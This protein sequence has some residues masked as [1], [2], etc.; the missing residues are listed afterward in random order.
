MLEKPDLADDTLV[1]RLREEYDLPISTVGF[2]P[3]GADS[4][5]AVYRAGADGGSVY[6]VKLRS[7]NWLEASVLVPTLLRDR[8]VDAVI[9]PISTAK[10]ELWTSLDAFAVILSPFV[11]GEDGFT[12][13]L[14]ESNWVALGTTLRLLHTTILPPMLH[15]QLP[16]ETY[17][18]EWRIAVKVFQA[19]VEGA[20]FGDPSATEL[21]RMMREQRE[22][23]TT[24]VERA[25]Q[26]ADVLRDRNPDLVLCHA[27]IHSGNV[28]IDAS[29]TLYVVDWDTL[30]IAPKERDLMFIGG[31]IGRGWN[32]PAEDALFYQGYGET[33]IDLAALT[34]YRYERIVQDI[35]AF[36]EQLLDSDE[37]GD[38]RSQALRFFGSQFQPGSVVE[39]AIATD[40]SLRVR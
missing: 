4:N 40:R 26:L 13:F 22:I 28:L 15:D 39:I 33:D 24:I 8:G 11:T 1:N 35:A 31:G 16:Q 6:F 10:G 17:S 37:G 36:C 2:L 32:T 25:E 30:T 12:R 5:T 9:A 19:R 14:S 34:Y 20:S 23:V 29:D 21:A 3:L 7:G 38:D 27:D 18:S